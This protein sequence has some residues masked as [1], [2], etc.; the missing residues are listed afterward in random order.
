MQ[1]EDVIGYRFRNPDILNEALTHSSFASEHKMKACNE[2]LEFLGDAVAG[3]VTAHYL[4]HTDQQGSEGKLAKLKGKLVSRRFFAI[5]AR[6]VGLGNSLLLGQGELSTGGRDRDSILSNAM[7]AV[8]G[9]I[10][11]DGGYTA[12]E[13]ILKQRLSQQPLDDLDAD[14]KS[15]LQELVQKRYKAPPEYELVSTVGPEH[16][17]NFT[18]EVKI[19]KRVLARGRGKNKKQAEQD[20]AKAALEHF[21]GEQPLQS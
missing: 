1:L 3:L 10:F 18:V 5:W 15:T 8:L 2:R 21:S 12:A 14:Y 11:L 4:Y 7:E 6:E 19:K 9:A 13:Q 20:A 17:K 16:N